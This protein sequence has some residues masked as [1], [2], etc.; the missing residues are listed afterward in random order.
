[1][2]GKEILGAAARPKA[3]G[4]AA[5]AVLSGLAAFAIAHAGTPVTAGTDA[6]GGAV[7]EHKLAQVVPGKSS[8]ARVKALLGTPW[9]VVQFN[10]C[11]EAMAG[12]SDETWD[13][14]GRDAGGTFRVHIEFDDRGIAHLV[15]KIPDAVA[16]DKGTTAKIASEDSMADMRM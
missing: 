6:A 5:A 8:K 2:N 10:D 9:R 16:G 11:G 13:Y 15:A 4:A 1:M 14:R 12:Q 3:A 7:N